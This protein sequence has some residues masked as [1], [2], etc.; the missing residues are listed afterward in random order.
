MA[1]QIEILNS[2]LGERLG[3]RGTH[4]RFAWK[5]A[6]ELFYF[7]RQNY[8]TGFVR[9]CW[10]QRLGKVWVLCQWRRPEMS[11]QQWWDSFHGEFPYPA[12]G[13]YY[14]HPETAL[15]PGELPESEITQAHIHALTA[16]MSKNY[17]THL[18]E[19]NADTARC[20]QADE[21]EWME[22]ATD[23]APAFNNWNSGKKSGVEFQVPGLRP[24]RVIRPATE[25]IPELREH[26]SIAPDG[27]AISSAH[28][29]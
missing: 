6:P 14:A 9:Q 27:S 8:L 1:N 24:D 26:G 28:Y 4:P 3:Y 5:Y 12:Q 22:Y 13:M 18:R 17:A 7:W 29:L 23:F 15:A 21:D 10:A 16:Q 20:E 2:R 11:Q 19:V 25:S